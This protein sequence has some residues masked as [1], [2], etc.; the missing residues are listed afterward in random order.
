M[1]FDR[2]TYYVDK[3]FFYFNILANFFS[4]WEDTAV[5]KIFIIIITEFVTNLYHHTELQKITCYKTTYV[6]GMWNGTYDP[7]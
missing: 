2:L 3:I 1:K 6:T 4:S 7:I 5:A